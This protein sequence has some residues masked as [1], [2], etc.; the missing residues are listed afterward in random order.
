MSARLKVHVEWRD[1]VD[2]SRV[3][4]AYLDA[5]TQKLLYI[6]KAD[7][8]TVRQRYNG[9][10]KKA[11][12]LDLLGGLESFRISVIVGEPV[13]ETGRRLS[14]ALLADIESLLIYR[15]KPPLNKQCIQSR[16]CR[17]GMV[18]TCGGEWPYRRMRFIDH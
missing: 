8:Q 2:L 13:L 3:L 16:I 14:S 12:F 9:E 7:Y 5:S 10:H 17:A 18:I 1:N 6:G 15:I 4:Y 11:M